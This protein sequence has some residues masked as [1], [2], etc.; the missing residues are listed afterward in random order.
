M[1]RWCLVVGAVA[2]VWSVMPV[3]AAGD[4][5]GD[6]LVVETVADLDGPVVV[7]EPELD[8]ARTA[9]SGA[10]VYSERSIGFEAAV[11]GG[12]F[13][14]VVTDDKVPVDLAEGTVARDAIYV[15]GEKHYCHDVIIRES[16]DFVE[17]PCFQDSDGDGRFDR[18]RVMREEG[19]RMDVSY[20]WVVDQEIEPIGYQVKPVFPDQGSPLEVRVTYLGGAE[21]AVRFQLQIIATS[22]EPEAAKYIAK[23]KSFRPAEFSAD[24]AADG[25]FELRLTHPALVAME[26]SSGKT[27][28]DT[29]QMIIQGN[30]R[31]NGSIDYRVTQAFGPWYS[32]VQNVV[33]ELMLASDFWTGEGSFG[34][35]VR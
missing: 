12:P 23:A 4:G 24:T 8:V 28:Y 3:L 32:R 31:D 30:L 26:K 17:Y 10:V 14:A 5:D 22:D 9:A 20:A 29:Q 7:R 15:S 16:E 18:F 27:G 34:M 1:K 2:A 19:E 13:E 25:S 35:F 33:G 6:G 11:L 21:D